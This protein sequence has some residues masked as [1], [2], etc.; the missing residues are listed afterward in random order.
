MTIVD[1]H[2]EDGPMRVREH[3]LVV[4][5]AKHVF[6]H[7]E[8]GVVFVREA[9]SREDLATY[10]LTPLLLYGLSVPGTSLRWVILTP[11]DNPASIVS[12]LGK[13]WTQADG[14][15][16]RPDVLKVSRHLAAS[17][18]DLPETLA[19]TDVR[20]VVAEG[21]DKAFSASVR[22][23]QEDA[24]WASLPRRRATPSMTPDQLNRCATDRHNHSS[25]PRCHGRM[26]PWSGGGTYRLARPICSRAMRSIGVRA[27]GSTPGRKGWRRPGDGIFT[28][29]LST[30]PYGCSQRVRSRMATNS[31]RPFSRITRRTIFRKSP[32]PWCDAGRPHPAS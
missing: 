2:D 24:M 14:L 13:A 8:Y 29:I 17:A 7:R 20:L 31:K 25:R 6:L 23:C 26:P 12:V 9:A 30:V 1:E 19:A 3:H 15:R 16:G 27:P 10:D 5:T 21:S 28:R 11:V 22:R 4:A 18:V 32:G